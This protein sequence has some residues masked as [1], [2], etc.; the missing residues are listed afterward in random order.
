LPHVRDSQA[1][2]ATRRRTYCR[3][4]HFRERVAP[5][6]DACRARPA[7]TVEPMAGSVVSDLAGRVLAGRYLLHG[8]VGPGASGRVDGAEA[9]RLRGRVA[10]KELN[11]ALD[12]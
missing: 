3:Q 11:A 7:T 10:G 12:E 9:T 6:R 8:A 1:G 2:R 4:P 5:H